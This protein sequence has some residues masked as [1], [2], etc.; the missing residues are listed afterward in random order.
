MVFCAVPLVDRLSS[1]VAFGA[2]DDCWLW[3]ASLRDGYGQIRVGKSVRSAHLVMYEL[4]VGAVPE[5][6]DLDHLCRVR[7][8]VNP[9]HLEPVTRR[10]NLMRGETMARAH[11]ER[12]PMRLRQ[13]RVWFC[14]SAAARVAQQ[15]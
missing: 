2:A 8:C 4:V 6:L 12:P 7:S 5:G 9:R 13:L 15:P 3:T 10:E 14:R 1:K 11:F